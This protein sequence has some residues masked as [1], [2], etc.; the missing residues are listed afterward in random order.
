[1]TTSLEI[2]LVS[3]VELEIKL[4]SHPDHRCAARLSGND[5]LVG[6]RFA[7]QN[8]DPEVGFAIDETVD[9]DELV[10]VGESQAS[11]H[12]PVAARLTFDRL[13]ASLLRLDGMEVREDPAVPQLFGEAI[14][15]LVKCVRVEDF[16]EGMFSLVRS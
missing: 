9:G 7:A 1:M 13:A 6:Y 16:S 3:P 8:A 11:F 2:S 5:I 15:G 12:D 10:D 14:F 4:A